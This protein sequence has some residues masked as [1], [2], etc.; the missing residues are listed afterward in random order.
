LKRESKVLEIVG[1]EALEAGCL[2][3]GL[4]NRNRHIMFVN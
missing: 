1:G 3:L 2:S 4:F